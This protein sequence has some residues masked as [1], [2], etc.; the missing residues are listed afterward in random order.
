MHRRRVLAASLCVACFAAQAFAASPSGSSAPAVPVTAA[1]SDATQVKV[2]SLVIDTP[3][4]RATPPG[5]RIGGGFLTITNAGSEADQLTGGTASFAD[6]V[7][8]HQTEMTG[9]VMHMHQMSDGVEIKPGQTVVFKPGAYHLMFVNVKAPLKQGSRVKATLNFAKAGP[10][11]VEFP[12][13]AIG[14]GAPQATQMPPQ[15]Q[16]LH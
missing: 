6:R 12:V 16:K 3:W 13:L 15:T 11:E 4:A 7:E 2:G 8:I 1:A 9:N 14:A 5:A 10:V